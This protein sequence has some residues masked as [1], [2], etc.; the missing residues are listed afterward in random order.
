M[1]T[2]QKCFMGIILLSG[3]SGWASASG[4]VK[5]A[6]QLRIDDRMQQP[7]DATT[8]QTRASSGAGSKTTIAKTVETERTTVQNVRP[9]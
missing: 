8:A 2:L 4:F 6:A 7:T 9:K 1:T 5:P 3:V